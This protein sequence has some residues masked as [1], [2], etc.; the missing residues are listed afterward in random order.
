[1]TKAI[2]QWCHQSG[3]VADSSEPRDLSH[4]ICPGCKTQM[5]PEKW[6]EHKASCDKCHTAVPDPRITGPDG[7]IWNVRT[8]D[9]AYD[10]IV[11]DYTQ[12]GARHPTNVAKQR[13]DIFKER[14]KKKQ[15]L[16]ADLAAR[17]KQELVTLAS[18]EDGSFNKQGSI[19]I[20]TLAAAARANPHEL[21]HFLQ[22]RQQE[23]HGASIANALSRGK[24]NKYV[25]EFAEETISDR[26]L[27]VQDIVN[28]RHSVNLEVISAPAIA[29]QQ[30]NADGATVIAAT[31][32]SAAPRSDPFPETIH[33]HHR[34]RARVEDPSGPQHTA[35][36]PS[37]NADMSPTR[38]NYAPIFK[39]SQSPIFASSKSFYGG[40]LDVI[41]ARIDEVS[42]RKFTNPNGFDWA[43][44]AAQQIKLEIINDRTSYN[45]YLSRQDISGLAVGKANV[46]V[47]VSIGKQFA[48]EVRVLLWH[49]QALDFKTGRIITHAP[50]RENAS[51]AHTVLYPFLAHPYRTSSSE[52]NTVSADADATK[53]LDN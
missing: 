47:N 44:R 37:D 43:L 16:Y 5:V 26:K 38:L 27:R 11:F 23:A 31:A 13:K 36:P 30:V 41:I 25:H 3:L 40:D 46:P 28:G 42:N 1:M 53:V 22:E 14:E 29:T 33:A 21:R 7:R 51:A 32:S 18:T 49:F 45:R 10:A 48:E 35:N 8:G 9:S 12:V 4:V 19:F 24:F 20:D 52:S 15:D 34:R 50:H 6:N 2:N 39:D 17:N